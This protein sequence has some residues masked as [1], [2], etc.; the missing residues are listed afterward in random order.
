MSRELS[1]RTV[2]TSFIDRLL[3]GRNLSLSGFRML[4][5]VFPLAIESFCLDGYDLV[6]SSSHAVAKGAI[7]PAG[8]VHVSYVHTPMRYVW[9]AGP[10]YAPRVP[11]G[12]LGRAAFG[13]LAHY[14]R[15]WDTVATT[16]VDAL[17]A[18]SRYT[19]DRIR[20]CYGRESTIIEPPVEVDRF[21][22]VPDPGP[23][24]GEPP[25][26]LCVSALVP[27]KRVD[28]AVRA[29]LGRR[30]RLVVVGEGADHDR[31]AEI[32]GAAP[33]IALRGRL[34][35]AEV[36]RL[37][38]QCQAV[39]HPAMD[40]FGIVP[41][42]AL[43]AGRPVVA[44]AGGGA[45]DSVRDGQ[46]GVLFAESTP[47]SLSDALTRLQGL[48]FDP[49]RLRVEARRFDRASFERRFAA[50]VESCLRHPRLPHPRAAP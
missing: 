28:L 17:V 20:R 24:T 50:L 14:L 44:F 47:A 46:T 15:L 11:G 40:D 34:D 41:V 38:A 43:A 39:I 16:R 12:T 48:R 29:F 8:A 45:T 7:A 42:E 49:A 5:P 6:V 1:G 36:D 10:E 22:R 27:Y 37:Y 30:E 31:L 19:R 25:L 3:R 13:V 4:L 9:E 23:P 35:D 18:N 32:A 21:E 33:N 2:R 26:Y